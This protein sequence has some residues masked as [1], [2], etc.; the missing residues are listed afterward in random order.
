MGISPPKWYDVIDIILENKE[1]L[2]EKI[3]N[4]LLKLRKDLKWLRTQREVAFYDDID[5][6]PTRDY[7]LKDANKAISIAKKFL[8]ISERI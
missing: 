5:F 1:K 7:T 2:T 4:E 6:I 3:A 8:E